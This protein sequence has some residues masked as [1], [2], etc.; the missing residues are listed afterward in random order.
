MK[1]ILIGMA[2]RFVE[3]KLQDMLIDLV[4]DNKE[5]L[6]QK[7]CFILLAGDGSTLD[8]LKKKVLLLKLQKNIIFNGNLSEKKI[9]NWFKKLDLYVHLSKDETTSTSILQAMSTGLPIIAS[10]VGGNTMLLKS[11]GNKRNI[12][13]VPND[14]KKIFKTIRECLN[15]KKKMA[16]LS[17]FSRE[18]TIN[19]FSNN[20]MFENYEKL[21]TRS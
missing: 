6:L 16:E 7:N 8:S 2:A 17:K 20:K 19:Y 14:R 10:K 4:S 3:D 5:Y 15:N 9:I 1:K 18:M 12:I 13:L 21:I 11:D